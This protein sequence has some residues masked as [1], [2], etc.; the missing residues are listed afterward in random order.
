MKKALVCT[1]CAIAGLL[2]SHPRSAPPARVAGPEITPSAGLQDSTD[3]ALL[4][5]ELLARMDA[6]IDAQTA[7]A[8]LDARLAI[9]EVIRIPYL[10]V[11]L[12]TVD[13]GAKI[14]GIY[15]ETGAAASGL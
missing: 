7:Q 4:R 10:G 11:D 13:G 3:P 15:P 12:E 9:D 1:A 8:H 2:L 6:R 5:R 14:T